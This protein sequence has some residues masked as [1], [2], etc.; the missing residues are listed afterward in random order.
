MLNGLLNCGMLLR[1]RIAYKLGEEIRWGPAESREGKEKGYDIWIGTLRWQ[2]S[3]VRIDQ[4]F[5]TQ[6]AFTQCK[7]GRANKLAET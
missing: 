2:L 3:V 7:S 5:Q 4:Q 1:K 6:Q